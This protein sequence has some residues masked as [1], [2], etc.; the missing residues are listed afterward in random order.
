MFWLFMS[1]WGTNKSKLKLKFKFK[2]QQI[3]IHSGH[4]VVHS[5]KIFILHRFRFMIIIIISFPAHWARTAAIRLSG[6]YFLEIKKWSHIKSTDRVCSLKLLACLLSDLHNIRFRMKSQ[7]EEVMNKNFNL[8]ENQVVY[9]INLT[10]SR[11]RAKFTV[12]KE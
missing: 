1:K 11:K 10:K 7:G 5:N 12:F 9:A 4:H 3:T 2:F 8:T 6:V